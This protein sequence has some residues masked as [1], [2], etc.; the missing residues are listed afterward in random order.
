MRKISFLLFLVLLGASN[1]YA[2][3]NVPVKA[4]TFDYRHE[5]KTRDRTHYDRLVMAAK[6]PS[7]WSFGVETKFRSGGHDTKDKAYQDPVLNAVEMTL[8]KS[9]YIGN[10]KLTA[11]FLQPEFNS[12]RTE[13][14]TGI[15]PWYT[16]NDHW[17]MGGL[18]RLE[19]T[20]YAHDDD[21]I[22]NGDTYCSTGKH[23]TVNRT[24]WYLRYTN[25]RFA[26][27]YKFIYKHGDKIMFANEHYDYEQEWQ[28]GYAMGDKKEW[29]PYITF[30]DISRSSH[31]SERQFRLRVGVAYTFK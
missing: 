24:D 22:S 17:A 13:W 4:L 30:G 27:T 3:V 1:V 11:I 20:D 9:Y 26:T 28:F 19:L 6:L 7:D 5:Y 16:F 21:C 25:G 8:A 15:S 23:K 10:W 2:D 31:S 29:S 18:Y 12:Q 14:K